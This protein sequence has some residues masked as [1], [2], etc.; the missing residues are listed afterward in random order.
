MAAII[1]ALPTELQLQI[2]DFLPLPD[3]IRAINVCMLWRRLISS[4]SFQKSRYSLAYTV[5]GV[6][7]LIG[8]ETKAFRY[9]LNGESNRESNFMGEIINDCPFLD[10]PFFSP[11]AWKDGTVE[12]YLQKFEVYLYTALPRMY[13][14]TWFGVDEFGKDITVRGFV[15]T[16][17]DPVLEALKAPA[18][19]D[20]T[21]R[22]SSDN[23]NGDLV[24][25]QQ[26]TKLEGY[27]TF[28]PGYQVPVLAIA[29][30]RGPLPAETQV[31]T[32][33]D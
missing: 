20:S 7:N 22:T 1:L 6:H 21:V 26:E 19:E 12:D 23:P 18:T 9:I 3:Q 31:Q 29:F 28:F 13:R 11:W 32:V 16:I 17:L 25:A 14:R 27:L 2:L 33:A 8:Y 4:N 5:P 30:T 24:E 10:E 15:E